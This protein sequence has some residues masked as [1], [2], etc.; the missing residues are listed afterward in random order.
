MERL[1]VQPIK[2]TKK[3][4]TDSKQRVKKKRQLILWTLR[5]NWYGLSLYISRKNGDHYCIQT[6]HNDLFCHYNLVL[7]KLKEKLPEKRVYILRE[8]IGSC[9]STSFPGFS[10]LLRERTPV[11]AGHV[12][13]CVNKLCSGGRSSTKFCR[14]DN[15]ILT[16][17]GRKFLLQN[18]A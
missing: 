7:G 18:S 10:F 6:R 3:S 15:G 2:G 12:E 13:V 11:A 5:R 8:Y 17:V 14:L 4:D 1:P 9:S 16:G